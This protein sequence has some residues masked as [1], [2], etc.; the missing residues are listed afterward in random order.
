MPVTFHQDNIVALLSAAD[1]T[2]EQSSTQNTCEPIRVAGNCLLEIQLMA[3]R[4]AGCSFFIIEVDNV[5]GALLAMVDRFRRDGLTL[6][7]A[8]SI[9]DLREL[10]RPGMQLI[11]QAEDHFYSDEIIADLIAHKK[12]FV[13]TIDSR[14]ENAD[15]ER[16][17][18]NTRWAGFA[19]LNAEVIFKMK[20]LPEDWS[21]VSTLLRQAVQER[22]EFLMLPQVHLQNR[23]IAKINSKAK[24][25]ELSNHI[26]N[27]R[28]K[29]SSG[30]VERIFFAPLANLLA[31]KFWSSPNFLSLTKFSDII[32]SLMCLV[33]A[34]LDLPIFALFLAL[35]GLFFNYLDLVVQGDNLEPKTG[36]WSD[37]IFWPVLCTSGLVVAYSFSHDGS[38]TISFM[39]VMIGL[40]ILA[41]SLTLP[42][43]VK[44]VLLSPSLIV[45]CLIL[46][47]LMS[48]FSTGIKAVVLAQL[49]F[50][51]AGRHLYESNHVKND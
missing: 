25:I 24:A 49:L 5:S 28:T 20:E 50:L 37:G 34:F 23:V 36:K 38:D 42:H 30:W 35:A 19:F 11:I 44:A 3:L 13:A 29:A 31:P 8:R 4:R 43:W 15:F 48:V 41:R 6:E 39:S 22:L 12:A 45:I 46:A 21:L 18:L 47:A 26:L 33:S 16:I 9:N 32:F 1:A 17:D 2:A 7:F 14:E 51:I 10:V 40:A 27:L